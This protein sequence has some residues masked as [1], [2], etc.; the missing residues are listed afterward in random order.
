VTPSRLTRRP[1]LAAPLLLGP[2]AALALAAPAC[3]SDSTQV[4]EKIRAAVASQL[5]VAEADLRTTCPED[6]EAEEGSEFDCSVEVDGQPLTA[7][8]QFTSDERFD[9][10]ID[11]QVFERSAI[12]AQVQEQL[13]STDFLGAPVAGLRCGDHDLVVIQK[14]QTITCR[15]TEASTGAAGGA[16]VA[17]DQ[18]GNA[19][20]QRMIP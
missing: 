3:S 17:L 16:E 10:S 18:S 6:A 5:K 7:H 14:A 2:A 12:E 13:E 15:G 9:L 4:A 20:V 19:V 1:R 11:G 8:V